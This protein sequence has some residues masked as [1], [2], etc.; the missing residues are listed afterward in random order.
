[1][2]RTE[3]ETIGGVPLGLSRDYDH[4]PRTGPLRLICCQTCSGLYE[5]VERLAADG[6][7]V[8][9][10]MCKDC[11]EKGRLK[12]MAAQHVELPTAVATYRKG[13]S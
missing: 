10:V 1:M 11:R 3:P 12:W 9:A 5:D 6:C 4:L 2:I 7:K 8:L 13:V